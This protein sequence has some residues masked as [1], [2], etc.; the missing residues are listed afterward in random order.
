MPELD[1]DEINSVKT[2]D[3]TYDSIKNGITESV[4]KKAFM[5]GENIC[6]LC[7]EECRVGCT[8]ITDR[9]CI[10]ERQISHVIFDK[11]I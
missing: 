10:A 7:H 9:D 5:D 6:R 1:I 8:G 3:I 11:G 2:G 4:T